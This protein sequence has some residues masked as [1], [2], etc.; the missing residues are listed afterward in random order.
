MLDHTAA[1]MEA[2][3]EAGVSGSIARLPTAIYHQPK[4]S[5]KG[6]KFGI[7]IRAFPLRVESEFSSWPEK[8]LRKRAWMKIDEA[9]IAVADSS[10]GA[11]LRSFASLYDHED[12]H[13]L[14]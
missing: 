4:V 6:R 8:R 9:Q 10:I 2:F 5:D 3:E 13:L 1:A 11:V 12:A 7:T 14:S